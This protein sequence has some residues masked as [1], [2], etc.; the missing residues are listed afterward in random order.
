MRIS[1]GRWGLVVMCNEL[2]LTFLKRIE[3]STGDGAGGAVM[4]VEGGY[5]AAAAGHGHA[6]RR[7]DA[8]AAAVGSAATTTTTLR[9]LLRSCECETMNVN[10][11][12]RL[13]NNHTVPHMWLAAV[14]VRA[15][16]GHAPRARPG[17]PH[18]QRSV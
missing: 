17:H 15:L 4:A 2:T 14:R 9:N 11:T 13:A 18:S 5:D 8:R 16:R 3:P 6:R 12:R 1:I 10:V 7:G